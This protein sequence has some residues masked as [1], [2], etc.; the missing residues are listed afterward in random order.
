M[1][2]LTFSHVPVLGL[3]LLFSALMLLPSLCLYAFDFGLLADQTVGVEGGSTVNSADYSGTLVPWLSTS[4]GSLPNTARLYVSAGLTVET[5][6]EGLHFIPELLR[7]ELTCPIGTGMEIKAGRMQYTDPPGFVATGLFDGARFSFTGANSGTFGAGVWYTG[8][9]YKKNAQITMTEKELAAYSAE[10]DYDDFTKTYFAPSRLLFALDWEN[11]YPAQQLKLKAAL[12]GQ[13]DLGGSDTFHSQYLAFKAG[14]PVKSFVFNA[15]VCLELA[16]ISVQNSSEKK[17]SWAGELGIEWILPTPIKDKLAL[18]ARFSGGTSGSLNAFVP[19]TA[20]NQGYILKAGFSGVS[21]ICLDY[22][23]R[24][25]EN[26]SI[27]FTDTYFIL[28]DLDTYQGLPSGR[29]G[30]A[31]GNE[32]YGRLIWSPLSDLRL[33]LGGGAFLPSMGNADSAGKAI[34]RVELNAVLAIF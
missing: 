16:E 12:M 32:F 26:F 3:R 9:L 17:I 2:T 31:L 28:S 11:S 22:T 29:A 15:G 30:F 25:D 10:P 24:L 20:G 27:S 6:K 5:T 19:V 14:I 34:W 7:T 8:L 33:N 13:F 21:T 4:L 1:K 18:I 23:A